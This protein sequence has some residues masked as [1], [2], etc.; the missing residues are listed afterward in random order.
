MT[1]VSTITDRATIGDRVIV[2][3]TF[4]NDGT[5]GDIETTLRV[6]EQLHIQ[7]TGD[8]AVA[9]TPSVN[10]TLPLGDRTSPTI[11]TTS[12]KAGIWMAIGY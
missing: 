9:E 12:A 3:G 8:A 4:T 6:V 5:G 7:H 11:V 10:E 2:F 1:L